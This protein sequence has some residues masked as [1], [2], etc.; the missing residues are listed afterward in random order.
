[1][2]LQE[3][4]EDIKDLILDYQRRLQS[5]DEQIALEGKFASADL[6]GEKGEIEKLLTRLRTELIELGD[7]N[8]EKFTVVGRE[9][10]IEHI[11]KL[12]FSYGRRIQAIR[13]RQ[14]FHGQNISRDVL[15]EIEQVSGKIDDLTIE[16]KELGV[17]EVDEIDPQ[18]RRHDIKKL[19]FNYQRRLQVL[20]EQRAL[21]G[22]DTPVQISVEIR[23]I[24]GMIQ[25]LN[26]EFKALDGFESTELVLTDPELRK[27][28]IKKLIVNYQR[29]LQMH[30]EQQARMGYSTPLNISSEI[31]SI[32]IELKNLGEELS[33]LEDDTEQ[34]SQI[35]D[36]TR[37]KITSREDGIKELI[38]NYQYRLR[39]LKLQ[40][41]VDGL[42]TA[43][44]VLVEIEDIR[45]TIEKL[46]AELSSLEQVDDNQLKDAVL[47]TRPK[48]TLHRDDI[49]QLIANHQR[50]L[51]K[52]KEQRALYGIVT[53]AEILIQIEDLEVEISNLQTQFQELVETSDDS[54][55][56]NIK[57]IRNQLNK[58]FDEPE[59]DAMI[60]DYFPEVY[61]NLSR[62][63]RKDE[64]ITI[65]LDACRRQPDGYDQLQEVITSHFISSGRVTAGVNIYA[66]D[67]ITGVQQNIAINLEQTDDTSVT[68][69]SYGPPDIVATYLNIIR[70]Q[71]GQVETRP[72]FQ[73]SKVA[74]APPRLSLI[75]E[76]GLGGVYI[77]LYF[78][79][80][81]QTNIDLTQALK[82]INHLV[83][84]GGA[85]SGKSTV[86][87]YVAMVLAAQDAALNRVKLAWTTNVLPLP[88]FVFLR[89]FEHVCQVRPETYQRNPDSLLRFIDDHFERWYPGRVPSGFL[90][91]LIK[92]GNAWILLDGLDEVAN[93]DHRVT[94]R[95]LLEEL[96]AIHP[97]NRILITA[98]GS[99]R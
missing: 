58:G 92:T 25:T 11:K 26:T 14:A 57:E 51:Q 56:H 80:P 18:L 9:E 84:V 27:G 31:E 43:P 63:M 93:F 49:E 8:I 90:S 64:K 77:P 41:E 36:D 10:R 23:N 69:P 40:E 82:E 65:L 81:S 72:Y 38:E 48:Q 45:V 21:Y 97:K 99:L 34:A 7:E 33:A 20:E 12:I 44:N 22:P 1:M 53:P 47:E 5:L 54:Q 15:F 79:K 32:R 73:L 86:L 17:E 19:I 29:R 61:N 37:Q 89:D 3:K 68:P 52:L 78:D 30:L 46:Q 50:R 42:D 16:L 60:L 91:D 88:I 28:D 35:E 62:G 94:I 55:T 66:Q 71:F 39:N 83:V 75:G 87:R 74:G 67:I 76:D 2:P 59:L 96:A 95:G 70:A 24:E 4:P 85:G 6:R 98:R 13:E